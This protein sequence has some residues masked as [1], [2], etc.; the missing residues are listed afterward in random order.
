M[1][2]KVLNENCKPLVEN[3]G[4][5]ID[6]RCAETIEYKKGDFL[7]IP[8]GVCIDVGR[9]QFG[10]LVPRSSTFKNWGFIQTNS[11]GI[12]DDSYSG[13]GDEWLMPV[14]CTRD[15]EIRE[16]DR[17][18]QFQVFDQPYDVI[19]F[20]KQLGGQNRGGFGTSGRK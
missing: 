20:V 18:C 4:N 2:I 7:M 15:G 1:R 19:Q 10:M 12:I 9:G 8:L 14:Y 17:V 5:F 6:L 11:V 13:D 3:N 16:G